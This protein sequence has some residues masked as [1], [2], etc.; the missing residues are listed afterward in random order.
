MKRVVRQV[1][2]V[3]GIIAAAIA[4]SGC[5][6]NSEQVRTCERIIAALEDDPGTVTIVRTA[7]HPESENGVILDY[8]TDARP[9]DDGNAGSAAAEDGT[10]WISCRFEND[11]LDRWFGRQTLAEVASDRTGKLTG[12]D[13]E[14]LRIWLRVTKGGA[15]ARPTFSRT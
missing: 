6:L 2:G 8:H 14:M 9:E 10:H 15:G 7:P 3:R 1:I 11:R 13:L 5:G 4:I 12:I